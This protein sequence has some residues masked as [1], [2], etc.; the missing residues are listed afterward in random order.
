MAGVSGDVPPECFEGVVR[1]FG[2]QPPVAFGDTQQRT[3]DRDWVVTCDVGDDVGATARRHLVDQVVDQLDDL[4][5]QTC[6][7]A[8]AERLGDESAQTVVLGAVE[9]ADRRNDPIPHRSAGDPLGFQQPPPGHTKPRVSQYRADESVG[10]D[11]GAVHAHRYR[12]LPV[13]LG[14]DRVGLVGL[15]VQPGR[16]RWQSGVENAWTCTDAHSWP[17]SMK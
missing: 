7:G 5:T 9:T 10:H 14:D 2:E 11:F 6:G 1:P 13:C 8:G 12:R 17:P 16:H 15:G 3:D 4:V